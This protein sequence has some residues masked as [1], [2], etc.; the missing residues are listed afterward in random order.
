MTTLQGKQMKILNLLRYLYGECKNDFVRL[1]LAGKAA[2]YEITGSGN[3]APKLVKY[4]ILERKGNNPAHFTYKWN[5]ESGPTVEMV[6]KHFGGTEF[7]KETGVPKTKIIPQTPSKIT[8][9]KN[10]QRSVTIKESNNIKADADK[11]LFALIDDNALI[12]ELRRRN[13]TGNLNKQISL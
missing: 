3:F 2:E 13:Y 1:N 7:T 8:S 10:P 12:E 5:S 6:I 9:D 4:G 11:I